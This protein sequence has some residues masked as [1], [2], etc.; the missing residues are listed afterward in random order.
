MKEK[1]FR[2]DMA[3]LDFHVLSEGTSLITW[4]DIRRIR[5]SFP[6]NAQTLY[7]LKCNSFPLSNWRAQ[8]YHAPYL[9]VL[10]PCLQWQD[11]FV[12]HVPVRVVTG[13]FSLTGG[14]RLEV[15][16][17]RNSTYGRLGWIF[18]RF[19]SRPGMPSNDLLLKM[20]R[21]GTRSMRYFRRLGN[22]GVLPYLR[23][24]MPYGQSGP[25]DGRPGLARGGTHSQSQ[26]TI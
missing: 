1:D 14:D 21:L 2:R 13:S 23:R 20:M 6:T 19:H 9:G 5:A 25:P 3:K 7:R 17:R 24:S 15:S 8:I 26:D 22:S 4:R 18:Q 10:G 12:G 11:M 16:A